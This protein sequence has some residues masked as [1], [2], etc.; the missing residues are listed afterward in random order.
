MSNE[1]DLKILRSETRFESVSLTPLTVF[2]IRVQ[3]KSETYSI[4][5]RF[6]QFATLDETIKDLLPGLPIPKFPSKSATLWKSKVDHDVVSKRLE[7]LQVWLSALL[8]SPRVLRSP[9]LLDW[10]QHSNDVSVVLLCVFSCASTRVAR[11][12]V[13]WRVSVVFQCVPVRGSWILCIIVNVCCTIRR[14]S[15]G[16]CAFMRSRSRS[17]A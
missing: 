2:V 16:C 1:L 13:G 15:L 5:R 3:Y 4:E 14:G 6:S 7:G 10:I 9:M 17:C 11:S 8:A 12:R